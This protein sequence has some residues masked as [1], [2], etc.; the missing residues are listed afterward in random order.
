MTEQIPVSQPP[1]Q[2][3]V[4]GF[5]RRHPLV[6]FVVALAVPQVAMVLNTLGTFPGVYKWYPALVKPVLTP[7]NWLFGPM[8]TVLFLLMGVSLYL[9]WRRALFQPVSGWVFTV[10]FVQWVLNASWSLVF[11]E[12][13]MIFPGLMILSALWVFI[14]LTMVLFWRVSRLAALLLVP[15][16]LWVSLAVY[17]NWG[18]WRLN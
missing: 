15:Y 18:I 13:R 5:F 2:C 11:F 1:S 14:V 16:L 3:P 9:V 6:Q 8:W 4:T 7:P 12:N 10:F 17:L